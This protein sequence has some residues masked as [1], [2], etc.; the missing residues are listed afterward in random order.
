MIRREAALNMGETNVKM[1]ID[2][3]SATLLRAGVIIKSYDVIYELLSDV[4]EL[5][6]GRLGAVEERLPLG[7]AEVR[8]VFGAGSKKVA[9]CI[10]TEGSLKKGCLIA[11]SFQNLQRLQMRICPGHTTVSFAW[12]K[13]LCLGSCALL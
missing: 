9:G 12:C 4:R 7:Q 11:V 1:D 3:S 2:Y 13:L 6:E 8:A 10:V 5:M